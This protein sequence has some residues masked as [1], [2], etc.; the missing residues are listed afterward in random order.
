[1]ATL[2]TVL[3]R[4]VV[5]IRNGSTVF[6]TQTT[7]QTTVRA[8]FEDALAERNLASGRYSGMRNGLRWTLVARPIDLS[9]Q[10]PPPQDDEA[11]P[12]AATSAQYQAA[13][14]ATTTKDDAKPKW[15]LQRLIVR[16]E[17]KSRP[18]EIETIRLVKSER[19]D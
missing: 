11:G 2:L 14:A 4:G 18:F 16:I 15:T 5:A 13:P 1:M 3:F 12:R 19:K 7:Q 9:R 6:D 8:V 17:T 10:L